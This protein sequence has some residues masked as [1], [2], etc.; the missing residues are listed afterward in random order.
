[1]RKFQ[2][3]TVFLTGAASG[4]GRQIA[5]QL[6]DLSCHLYLVDVDEHGLSSLASELQHADGTVRTRVCDLSQPAAV[7]ACLADFDRQVGI[8]DVVINNA[9]VAY[10]GATEAMTQAQWDWLMN[11]NLLAPIRITNHFLPQLLQR[12]DAHV[13]N[14]CSI[15]G[16]VAG[17]RFAAY[18]AS[19]F[20]LIGYTEALRAEYG[21]RGIGVT[22]ICP[23][24]V[25]TNLYESAA[26][27]RADRTVPTPPAWLC[28]SAERVASLTINGMRRNKR[29]VIITPMAHALF[30]MKR[31]V[32]G[33][34][35][36]ANQFSRSRKKRLAAL[37]QQEQQRL[38]TLASSPLN[39][40]A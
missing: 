5:R 34:I 12:P 21:R 4:I 27:G 38:A 31:F 22:A 15:S 19:K 28:T 11:I 6:A 9:G 2:G 1:M 40:A 13:V 30:Q 18:H 17:G 37:Q 3:K 23:G 26:S 35:D 25:K 24:P 8:I 7:D 29:Q 39:K 14:M 16:I 20:G 10:Y 32:P 33:L 36:F